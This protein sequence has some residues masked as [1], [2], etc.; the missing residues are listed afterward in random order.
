MT[1]YVRLRALAPQLVE[2]VERAV[3]AVD[4]AALGVLDADVRRLVGTLLTTPAAEPAVVLA[5]LDDLYRTLIVRCEERRDAL[6]RSIGAKQRAHVGAAAYRSS[7]V[8]SLN[9]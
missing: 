9:A 4:F 5:E 7:G 3:D 2:R 1:Q 6:K 8:V